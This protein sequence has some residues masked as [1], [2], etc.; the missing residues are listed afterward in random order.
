M[1]VINQY[2]DGDRLYHDR[3]FGSSTESMADYGS[4][5]SQKQA[6]VFTEIIQGAD[7]AQ[8][9]QFVTDWYKLGGKQITDD[10]NLWNSQR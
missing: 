7:V 10:V 6:Q 9:D 8:F 4:I 2:V 1:A 3:Y 5:L